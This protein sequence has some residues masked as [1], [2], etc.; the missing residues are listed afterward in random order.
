M[1]TNKKKKEEKLLNTFFLNVSLI[2]IIFIIGIF[3]G[4][5]IRN[6]TLIEKEILT[7]ARTHFYTIVLTR[8][9]NAQYNG[10]YVEKKNGIKSNPYLK[11]PD[12]FTNDGKI[13]TK[14][15]PALM[16]REI[17][18]IAQKEDLFSFHITSLKPINPANQ[19]DTFET[20]A[21]HSFENNKKEY[22]KKLKLDNKIIF[23]YMAPLYTE[24]SCL[25]CHADQNYKIGD[26]RGGISLTYNITNINKTIKF[27]NLLFISLGLITIALFILIIYGFIFNLRN[28][29]IAAYNSLNEMAITDDLTK[30]N[31]RRYFFE[32]GNYLFNQA[33]RYKKAISVIMVDIDYFKKINDTYGHQNGD[34]ILLKIAEIMKTNCRKSDLLARYGGEEFIKL[35]P[36]TNID[37]AYQLAKKL[38]T[39]V[40]NTNFSLDTGKDIK[41]TI[42]IGISAL[43]KTDLDKQA[44]LYT[45]I[46]KADNALYEAKNTGRNKIVKC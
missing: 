21:L 26:I 1:K 25:S 32:T 8:K 31:N 13:Y 37:G 17:S 44:E 7:R 2:I 46:K 11:N 34:L 6:K 40:E 5:I 30:I 19:A 12:I 43:D 16:T 45:L 18:E 4:L 9:W 35:L 24:K 10:I 14:K 27:N 15:N 20:T 36:E 42:S 33:I 41:L 39:I 23:R 22:Y 29:L 28:K 3:M 38:K